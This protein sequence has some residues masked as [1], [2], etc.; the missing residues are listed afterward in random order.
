MGCSDPRTLFGK[1]G[2]TQY[3]RTAEYGKNRNEEALLF[4]IMAETETG[5]GF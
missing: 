3:S 5:M 2:F 1:T 4:L